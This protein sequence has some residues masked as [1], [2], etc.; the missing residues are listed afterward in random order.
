MISC[1]ERLNATDSLDMLADAGVYGLSLYAVGGN[2]A[3]QRSATKLSG[4][5]QIALGTGVLIEVLR[6]FMVGREPLSLFI[7]LVGFVAL[8]AN[9][10]CLVLISKHRDS[11]VHMRASWIFSTNDVIANLGVIIAG[12]LVWTLHSSI[13][14]LLIGTVISILVVRSGFMILREATQEKS[15]KSSAL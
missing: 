7:I 14:D 3:K 6:R 8:I 11:G 1:F 12:I 4:Y 5:F 2:I 15:C 10:L 13:P 9:I